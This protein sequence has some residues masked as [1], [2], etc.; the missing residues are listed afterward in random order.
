MS[1][2]WNRFLERRLPD[3]TKAVLDAYGRIGG[4]ILAD[5]LAYNALFALLP[6]LL[7]VV[8]VIGFIVH[9]PAR[10]ASIID[11]IAAQVPPLRDL[12]TRT[13]QA[14]S[15]GV[16]EISIVGLLA[17]V[18]GASRFARALDTSFSRVFN[19][20]PERSIVRR[21]LVGVASVV[22]L[23][24]AVVTAVGLASV[25]SFVMADLG[26]PILLPNL[27]RLG[28]LNPLITTVATSV[29]VGAVYRFMP[30]HHPRWKAIGVPAI[31]VGI[32]VALFTQAFAFIA[33][34][35][36]GIAALYGAIAA[37]FAVLAWL[38]VTAQ[39]LLIGM[40]WVRFREEGWPEL[41][42]GRPG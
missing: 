33:P 6:A 31:L 11:A 18:W 16:A 39:L 21:S 23:I 20:T 3:R 9:D 19:R 7:L 32:G 14:I 38:S 17:L 35:L 12:L 26:E 15:E 4:G 37:V 25:A 22:V 42:A 40:V 30:A 5:G 28:L 29:G 8:A 24:I 34:R 2:A 41:E 27:G 10:Q 13:F 36:I 1:S